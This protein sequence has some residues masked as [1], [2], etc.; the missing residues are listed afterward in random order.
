VLAFAIGYW[1]TLIMQYSV[2]KS[3][4][5]IICNTVGQQSANIASNYTNIGLC[6]WHKAE[7]IEAISWHTKALEIFLA[8]FGEAHRSVALCYN[9]LGLCYWQSAKYPDAIDCYNNALADFYR[10][11]WREV[12]VCWQ[13]L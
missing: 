10:H 4:K 12:R 2:F 6:Y 11:K 13:L 8:E 7:Y 3:I 1:V 5:N 9:N